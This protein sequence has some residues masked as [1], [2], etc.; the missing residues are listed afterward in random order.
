M[1]LSR[2]KGIPKL[3]YCEAERNGEGKENKTKRVKKHVFQITNHSLSHLKQ[4]FDTESCLSQESIFHSGVSL[5][6]YLDFL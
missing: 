5:N 2:K 4:C 6:H 1:L 3:D